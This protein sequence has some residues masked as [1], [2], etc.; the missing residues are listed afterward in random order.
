MSSTDTSVESSSS[1][2]SQPEQQTVSPPTK[3]QPEAEQCQS[4]APSI[5]NTTPGLKLVI[6][7]IDNTVR[8]RHQRVDVQMKSL[9]HVQAYA[10]KDRVN[11][12][13]LSSPAGKPVLYLISLTSVYQA[14]MENFYIIVAR[15]RVKFIPFFSEAFRGLL[16]HTY[17]TH[18]LVGGDQLTN[19]Q[20][21]GSPRIRGNS[22]TSEEQL[23]S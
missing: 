9:H 22:D 21:H 5:V 10:V 12:S 17:H 15:R 6:D 23:D 1:I 13:N 18:T 7:N 14:L 19:A 20:I 8:P 3:D 11:Y 4:C 2:Q 16:K